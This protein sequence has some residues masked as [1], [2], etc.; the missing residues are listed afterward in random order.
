V[1]TWGEMHARVY[2]ST[3][4][5][6]LA[7]VCDS[8]S[9]RASRV[10]G[11]FGAKAY[12]DYR[13][14]LQDPA[15]QAVSVVLP[16]FLHRDAA[17]AAARAGKHVLV[18]K[19]LA[20]TE[21]ECLEI[22]AEAR[23][24]GVTLF[25]DFHNR[26]SPLFAGLKQTLDSGEIGAPRHISY[27]LSDTT[28]VPR[29]MLPWA[30]RSTVAWFL[31]SHCLDTLLWLMDSRACAA[32]GMGDLPERVYCVKRDGVLREQYG[33]DTPDSYH[34]TIEWRSGLVTYVENSWLLPESGPTVVDLKCDVVCT[35]GA[36]Q[37]DGSHHGA[38]RKLGARL[39][40]P[41]VLV[42]PTIQGKPT[43]FGT[44]SIRH[45]ASSVASGARP[46]VDGIDGMAV[47]R[48]ILRM[49]ESAAAR[50]PVAVGNLYAA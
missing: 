1:G 7:A 16:D 2:A 42:T 25:V 49:E 29:Q 39:A 35:G 47:T 41:D 13:G 37:I 15:V 38:A 26:W 18:E 12:G 48:F 20:T 6:R 23:A 33:V 28:F 43:G 3:P 36:F 24:A 30:A 10:G 5:A 32:G 4:G 8:D 11:S 9:E 27:R 17:V 40:Y 34:T 50:A 22:I 19:P 45:F 44:E 21:A 31:A 46:L 14:L